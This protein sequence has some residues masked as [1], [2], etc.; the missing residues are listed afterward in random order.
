MISRCIAL[1]GETES[2]SWLKAE[3]QLVLDLYTCRPIGGATTRACM[4][5]LVGWPP[6]RSSARSSSRT[7]TTRATPPQPSTRYA[8]HTQGSNGPRTNELQPRADHRPATYLLLTRA[9]LAWDRRTSSSSRPTAGSSGAASRASSA[10]GL[11]PSPCVAARNRAVRR[12]AR[13]CR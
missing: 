5:A 10:R 7:C 13:S 3:S 2:H 4:R 12:S 11:R 6:L 9:G 8:R 1:C